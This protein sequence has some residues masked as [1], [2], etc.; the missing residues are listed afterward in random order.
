MGCWCPFKQKQQWQHDQYPN[1][2]PAV[3][4]P[5][6]RFTL[7]P[8]MS[9]DFILK[10]TCKTKHKHYRTSSHCSVDPWVVL[11]KA[12]GFPTL[13]TLRT[14]FAV[15]FFWDAEETIMLT[16]FLP[17]PK[18]EQKFTKKIHKISSAL[19][20]G[21][22][23]KKIQQWKGNL[24][25]S[26]TALVQGS[27]RFRFLVSGFPHWPASRHWR[28]GAASFQRDIAWTRIKSWLDII[29]G[30]SQ[31]VVPLEHHWVN[32]MIQK[33]KKKN[34]LVFACFSGE[35]SN[36]SAFISFPCDLRP[37]P[38]WL[39]DRLILAFLCLKKS[40]KFSPFH[41]IVRKLRRPRWSGEDFET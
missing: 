8:Y 35:V 19:L 13:A 38:S 34:V 22:T 28:V 26:E 14:H 5:D 12:V 21:C 9:L 23:P 40:S 20:N 2:Q 11:V 4:L 33:R 7:Y 41:L 27:L 6:F 16:G 25:L 17:N 18:E 32:S 30:L 37:L 15:Y 24:G 31:I 3:W 39:P 1:N 36:C 10:I 29:W